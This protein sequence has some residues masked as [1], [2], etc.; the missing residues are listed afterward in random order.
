MDSARLIEI[1]MMAVATGTLSVAITNAHI[2][3]PLRLKLVDAPLMLGELINC[4]F[5]MGFWISM[6]LMIH[7]SV[8]GWLVVWGLG[9]AWSGILLRLFL[10]RESENEELRDVIREMRQTV[11]ELVE[12]EDE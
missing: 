12:K 6:G 2:S 10:F 7:I 1:G 9:A 8:L 5:C 4:S 11:I 3:R